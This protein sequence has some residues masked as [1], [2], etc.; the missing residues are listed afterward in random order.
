MAASYQVAPP[1]TFKFKTPEDWPK[2]IQRFERFRC[3]SGLDKKGQGIQVNTLVYCM[4]DEADD[5]LGSF[6]LSSEE[7]EQYDVVKEK[8]E[9][10]FVKRRNVIF[11]R[12]KF[13]QQRQEPGE[14]IDNFITSLHCL[15]EHCGYGN[16]REQMIRDRIVVR[17]QDISLSEKLQLEPNLTLETAVT[18]VRQR[19]AVKKQQ[20]TVRSQAASTPA[21][22]VDALQ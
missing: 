15:S 1:E 9:G 22:S 21:A 19:E 12:A 7:K 8:F 14:P 13:N 20:S 10:Y 11:E 4:G 2:W 6:H 5:I 3:A 16:L 18:A 17:I